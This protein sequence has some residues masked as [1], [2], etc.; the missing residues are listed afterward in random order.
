MSERV[1]SLSSF[2]SNYIFKEAF[3][4]SEPLDQVDPE[5]DS[6]PSGVHNDGMPG[7]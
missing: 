6:G 1:P 7:T 5:S 3:L 4:S 2:G